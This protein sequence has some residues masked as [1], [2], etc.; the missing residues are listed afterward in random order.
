MKRKILR[1][2]IETEDP[3]CPYRK[4]ESPEAYTLMEAIS[5]TLT[6]ALE[7]AIAENPNTHKRL[8]W[9]RWLLRKGSRY[10]PW[11][12]GS[13]PTDWIVHTKDLGDFKRMTA[14][15]WKDTAYKNTKILDK[16]T[17]LGRRHSQSDHGRTK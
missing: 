13:D 1:T 16:P 6:T 10:T 7:K 2:S 15:N 12:L 17:E 5:K 9:N 4:V 11:N 8:I 3:D 14:V